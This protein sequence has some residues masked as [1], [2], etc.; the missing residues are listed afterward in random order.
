MKAAFITSLFS[1]LTSLV[2]ILGIS[3]MT[4]VPRA[5][6]SRSYMMLAAGVFCVI[7]MSLAFWLRPRPSLASLPGWACGLLVSAE[8]IYVLGILL[9]VIG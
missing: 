4:F 7:W 6:S 1:T 9:F 5:E 8:A 2:A 3:A